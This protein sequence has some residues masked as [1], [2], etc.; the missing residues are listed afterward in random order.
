MSF[1][2]VV[3]QAEAQPEH[4]GA[5]EASV[6]P[7]SPDHDGHRPVDDVNDLLMVLAGQVS[8]HLVTGVAL[9]P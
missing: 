6:E 7:A 2:H 5:Q 9:K 1:L 4:L 8:E 3:S